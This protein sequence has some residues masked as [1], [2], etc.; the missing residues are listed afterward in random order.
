[1]HNPTAYVIFWLP[2]G[3]HFENGT[4][5]ADSNYESLMIRFL[6]DLSSGTPYLSIATQYPDDMMGSPSNL[7]HFGGSWID[8][9]S[10]TYA[11]GNLSEFSFPNEIMHA[12]NVNHWPEGTDSVYFLFTAQNVQPQLLEAGI[13]AYHSYF[14]DSN[15]GQNVVWANIPDV[16][17]R[18]CEVPSPSPNLDLIADSSINLMSHELF[19]SITDPLISAWIDSNGNEIG[20]KCAWTFGPQVGNPS[21]EPNADIQINGHYYEIQQEWSNA[22]NGCTLSGPQTFTDSLTITPYKYPLLPGDYFPVSYVIGGQTFVF[23]DTGGSVSILTDPFSSVS[24]D[25]SSLLS[26]S[27][28]NKLWCFDS[29]CDSYDFTSNAS[30]ITLEYYY[31]VGQSVSYYVSD[32]SVPSSSPSLTY[33]T[34]PNQIGMNGPANTTILLST[35]SQKIWILSGSDDSISLISGKSGEQWTPRVSSYMITSPDSVTSIEFYHQY[36]VT[37]S[38]TILGGGSGFTPPSINYTSLGSSLIAPNGSKVW[39]DAGSSYLYPATLAG[40]SSNEQW[41]SKGVISAKVELPTL[42][43]TLYLNQY[44]VNLSVYPAG[45]GS[46]SSQSG[47][48]NAMTTV[49]LSA[50]PNVGWF[51]QGWSGSGVNSY[52]GTT[53]ALKIVVSSPITENALFSKTGGASSSTTSITIETSNA[54]SSGSRSSGL[55]TSTKTTLTFSLPSISANAAM[56]WQIGAISLI[57]A[58]LVCFGYILIRRRRTLN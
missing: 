55:T 21:Q 12:I 1:M 7:L 46:L 17:Q 18:T 58:V 30:N 37:F 52:S 36:E 35:V 39:V 28:N 44:Y 48:Y 34:A 24:I 42:I 47:W 13:C 19:E 6:Q 49:D 20:D 38:S 4:G 40:S 41:I 3:H 56:Y 27:A 11:G 57:V 5:S 43:S 25:G 9:T 15:T 2:S 51:F 8:N 16:P 45:S 54:L 29:A 50:I 31:L 23:H 14:T 26:S 32:G 22:L 53:S 33:L 10:Y